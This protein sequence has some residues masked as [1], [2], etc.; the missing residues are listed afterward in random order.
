MFGRLWEARSRLYRRRT[1]QVNSKYSFERKK[2]E[3]RLK[4]LDE[5]YKIYTYAS[6]WRKEPKLHEITLMRL[7]EHTFAPLRIQKFSWIS[8][9][10]FAFVQLCFQK[11]FYYFFMFCN[12]CPT[13]TNFDDFSEMSACFEL[14]YGKDHKTTI[15]DQNIRDSQISVRFRNES[16]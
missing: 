8:S 16:C 5:I 4:A 12:C 10:I 1:L 15:K 7:L 6:F 9:N 13:F 3:T 14:F 11:I 2:G